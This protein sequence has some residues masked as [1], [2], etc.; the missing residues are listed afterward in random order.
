MYAVQD[1]SLELAGDQSL[2]FRS[3]FYTA[4]TPNQPLS[5]P[6]ALCY[7]VHPFFDGTD[8]RYAVETAADTVT[9]IFDCES[10]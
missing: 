4:S 1:P 3:S 2:C 8:H 5:E 10:D 9:S 7:K 6:T